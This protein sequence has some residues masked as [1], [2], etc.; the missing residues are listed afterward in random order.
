[1]K[2]VGVIGLGVGEAHAEA[3]ASH[4]DCVLVALC[5]ND[6]DRLAALASRYPQARAIADAEELL[7]DPD[8]DVVSIASYD[9]AHAAQA[10]TALE[11][12]KHV[13]V[14]KPLCRSLDELE[15]LKDAWMRN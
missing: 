10:T 1:M 15:L 9:D 6:G 2:R 3:Y 12:G 11:Y 5:D 14:E 4:P 8:I 7:K 13:F